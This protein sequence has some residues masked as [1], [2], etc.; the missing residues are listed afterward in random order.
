MSVWTAND[1]RLDISVHAIS[2]KLTC[3]NSTQ[4]KLHFAGKEFKIKPSS[5]AT[6]MSSIY[7]SVLS[8]VKSGQNQYTRLATTNYG[9]TNEGE[10]SLPADA[11]KIEPKVWL[12]SER[13]LLNYFRV[14]LLI[15]SFALT[16][17]N[18]AGDGDWVAKGMGM[19]YCFIALGMLLYAWTMHERRR[20]RI[21]ERY[22]G[23]HGKF[24]NST[25]RLIDCNPILN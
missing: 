8:L 10:Q 16:L 24:D 19:S 5:S 1:A 15:S 9:S 22:A 25:T 17:F 20:K 3:R 11:T 12:A 21:M 18:S 4:V 2:P 6:N 7:N 23:H 13:T 14:S